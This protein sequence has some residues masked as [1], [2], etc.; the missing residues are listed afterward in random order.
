MPVSY[1]IKGSKDAKMDA[2]VHENSTK[3]PKKIFKKLSDKNWEY[4]QQNQRKC[5]FLAAQGDIFNGETPKTRE[6]LREWMLNIRIIRYDWIFNTSVS[7]L[8]TN[9]HVSVWIA[10]LKSGFKP[11]GSKASQFESWVILV[12]G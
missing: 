8:T 6:E 12:I 9:L 1:K 2:P 5:Q 4:H 11:V 3:S 10:R 7:L